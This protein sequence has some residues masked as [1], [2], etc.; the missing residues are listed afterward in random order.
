[1]QWE[2][3][4]HAQDQQLCRI[5]F[6]DSNPSRSAQASVVR[7][8][9]GAGPLGTGGT[10]FEKWKAP[11]ESSVH[12]AIPGGR[13]GEGR[14][15]GAR[16][17]VPP[18]SMVTAIGIVALTDDQRRDWRRAA[19]RSLAPVR[20]GRAFRSLRSLAREQEAPSRWKGHV[21]LRSGKPL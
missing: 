2:F 13:M 19:A 8:V 14:A 17:G 20:R 18:R 3:R 10:H 12:E 15:D 21:H 7:E 4:N 1:G 6:E 11:H 5:G 16:T 9:A